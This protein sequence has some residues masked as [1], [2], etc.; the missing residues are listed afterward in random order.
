M[1]VNPIVLR[2]CRGVNFDM[3]R[4]RRD[5]DARANWMSSVR[6]NVSLRRVD[7]QARTL[8]RGYRPAEFRRNAD[9][10]HGEE[11]AR[12]RI[13]RERIGDMFDPAAII[14]ATRSDIVSA[15]S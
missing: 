13:D 6:K 7:P 12:A 11:S 3:F 9:E 10:S 14:T 1:A 4:T 8:P 2:T 15:S 5:N